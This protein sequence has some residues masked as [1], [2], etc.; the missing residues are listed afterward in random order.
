MIL[1]HQ[2]VIS[3][4][5]SKT[6]S[7]TTIPT[8]ITLS[9]KPTSVPQALPPPQPILGHHDPEN[10]GM[11]MQ[12]PDASICSTLEGGIAERLVMYSQEPMESYRYVQFASSR[13][14]ASFDTF[15]RSP[16]PA[17]SAP[18]TRSNPGPT[19]PQ[20][21]RS[22]PPKDPAPPSNQIQT[23]SHESDN[24]HQPFTLS[25]LSPHK[26]QTPELQHVLILLSP[27][28]SGPTSK[29]TSPGSVRHNAL[30]LSPM[31]PSKKR[32]SATVPAVINV[33][34]D[35]DTAADAV[36]DTGCNEP[37]H[38]QKRKRETKQPVAAAAAASAA[39][40]FGQNVSDVNGA[41]GSRGGAGADLQGEEA[42]PLGSQPQKEGSNAKVLGSSSGSAGSRATNGSIRP[43][44]T[45]KVAFRGAAKPQTT[46]GMRREARA[47]ARAVPRSILTLSSSRPL[48]SSS[49]SAAVKPQAPPPAPRAGAK[50]QEFSTSAAV[51]NLGHETGTLTSWNDNVVGNNATLAVESSKPGVHSTTA[52]TAGRSE[53]HKEHVRPNFSHLALLLCCHHVRAVLIIIFISHKPHDVPSLH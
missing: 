12:N 14:N 9:C 35:G 2:T 34:A 52:R 15:S 26:R 13:H 39:L 37:R 11:F 6:R 4:G 29:N 42:L 28:S 25:Q 18:R 24:Q 50:D 31:R 40:L 49:S 44:P 16:L 53:R 3:G 41:A 19:S 21:S 48:P 27:R 1:C 36:F 47:V 43:R 30:V 5:I 8:S 32:P 45:R 22:S 17:Q 33:N 38:V 20:P 23:Q 10:A 51:S 46:G 7:K